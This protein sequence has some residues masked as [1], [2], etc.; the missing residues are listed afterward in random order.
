MPQATPCAASPP[1][2]PRDHRRRRRRPAAQPGSAAA[3]RPALVIGGMDRGV[4]RMADLLRRG[5]TRCRHLLASRTGDRTRSPGRQPARPHTTGPSSGHVPE[6]IQLSTC[7]GVHCHG[8]APVNARNR[9][10]SRTRPSTSGP[11]SRRAACWR[12]HP[13]SIASNNAGSGRSGVASSTST[14]A[15]D[16]A[17]LPVPG[18]HPP[19]HA[20]EATDR[21]PSATR[22]SATS[23]QQVQPA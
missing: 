18:R 3:H 4:A 19:V 23:W 10:T 15:A 6:V 21:L 17:A 7:A 20:P 2:S 5:A 8:H 14:S 13:S 1:R 22:S 12:C 16:P 11:L 9:R